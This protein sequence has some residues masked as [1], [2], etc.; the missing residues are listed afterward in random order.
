MPC[1]D[2]LTGEA[3]PWV[4]AG[5]PLW[6]TLTGNTVSRTYLASGDYYGRVIVTDEHGASTEQRFGFRLRNVAPDVTID[7]PAA[8]TE[9]TGTPPSAARSATPAATR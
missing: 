6:P 8:A 7:P 1:I 9:E 3:T 5:P 2:A 4:C